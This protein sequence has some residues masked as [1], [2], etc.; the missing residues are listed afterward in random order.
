[1]ATRGSTTGRA[2]GLRLAAGQV[3]AL[4]GPA[5]GRRRFLDLL[6]D[7]TARHASGRARAPLARVAEPLDVVTG[8]TLRQNLALRSGA[9]DGRLPGLVAT[10]P[11]LAEVL[12][13]PAG[14]LDG[15]A[16]RRSALL[17]AG[18]E[19]AAA[20]LVTGLTRGLDAAGRRRLLAD[21][22]AVAAWPVAVL[23][24]DPDP[25]AALAVADSV[26]RVDAAGGGAWTERLRAE[27]EALAP[28]AL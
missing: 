11:G 26:L 6:D 25:V 18:L 23:V 27:P 1:M 21:L 3:A 10:W 9:G 4:A 5:E 15:L 28:P 16:L 22:P 14:R 12:D 2:S 8:L 7:A 20:L 19:G 17:L 13:D 24:D